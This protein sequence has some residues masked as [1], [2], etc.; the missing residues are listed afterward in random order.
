MGKVAVSRSVSRFSYFREL[1]ITQV[2]KQAAFSSRY[3]LVLQ[4][5]T[6]AKWRSIFRPG[7]NRSVQHHTHPAIPKWHIRRPSGH[8]RRQT[9]R[10]LSRY[11]LK[12]PRLTHCLGNFF[13][14][15]GGF[16][17]AEFT[18]SSGWSTF[19][20]GPLRLLNWCWA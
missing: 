13:G 15:A 20:S 17:G 14:I 2:A 5:A 18:A 9:E 11:I 10:R 6:T 3:R 7:R 4:V 1:P 8:C 19:S 16:V 12:G